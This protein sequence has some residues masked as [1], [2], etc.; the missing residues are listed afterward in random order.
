MDA[1]AMA[2]RDQAIRSINAALDKIRRA[3][4]GLYATKGLGTE[5][6]AA[7]L[8]GVAAHYRKVRADL[9]RLS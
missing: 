3:Q 8:D 6:C 9:Q 7:V 5:R 2:Q 1:K 4:S